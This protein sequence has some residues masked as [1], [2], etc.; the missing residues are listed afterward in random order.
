MTRPPLLDPPDAPSL[1]TDDDPLAWHA[2][3]PLALEHGR[4]TRRIDLWRDGE[5]IRV[6]AFFRDVNKEPDGREVIVHEYSLSA[7]IDPDTGQLDGVVAEP[8]VLPFDDCP[9]AAGHVSDLIGVP[10]TELAIDIHG[11]HRGEKS[12]THLNDMVRFLGDVPEL[13]RRHA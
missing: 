3:P 10:V 1:A 9:F 6:D 13:V 8:H 11:R 4:R 7:L 5:G 12:C 2:M